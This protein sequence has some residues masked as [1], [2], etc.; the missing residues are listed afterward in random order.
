MG[1]HNII[2]VAMAIR[3]A[4]P[5]SVA[6]TVEDQGRLTKNDVDGVTVDEGTVGTVLA[7][8]LGVVLA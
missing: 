8:A 4:M 3:I 5:S 2:A 7:V 1:C 6:V